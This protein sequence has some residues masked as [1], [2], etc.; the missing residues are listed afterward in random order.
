MA[1]KRGYSKA[2]SE[3]I[4]QNGGDG[5]T[6]PKS[7]DQR[8]RSVSEISQDSTASSL[9]TS[10]SPTDI[11]TPSPRSSPSPNSLKQNG[12]MGPRRDSSISGSSVG[13]L[14][15][16]PTIAK[17]SQLSMQ[18]S[19]NLD[20]ESARGTPVKS[21]DPPPAN[22]SEI[23]KK[24]LQAAKKNDS[25]SLTRLLTEFPN[26][27][28]TAVD[29]NGKTALH[30]CANNG[31]A[32][33][34]DTLLSRGAQPNM[35][36][37]NGNT[38]LHIAAKKDAVEVIEMLAVN[39]A[40][41]DFPDSK[42]GQTALH[43]AVSK[44]F[45]SSVQI[46][47]FSGADTTIK[48]KLGKAPHMFCKSKEM[49][50]LLAMNSS[51][52][53]NFSMGEMML[54]TVEIIGG[55]KTYCDRL[56]VHIDFAS[57][58]VGDKFSMMCRRQPIDFCDINFQFTASEEVISDVITYRVQRKGRKTLCMFTV[59]IYGQP[60]KTEEVVMKSN[61]GHN[62]VVSKVFEKDKVYYCDVSANL[63][64]LNAF[65]FV[66]RTKQESFTVSSDSTTITSEVNDNVK[67]ILPKGTFEEP[68]TLLL[69]VT[70]PPNPDILESAEMKDVYSLT[71]FVTVQT[72]NHVGPKQ[73][74]HIQLPLPEE[75]GVG[76]SIKVFTSN[77]YEID[78]ISEN[79]WTLLD[80]RCTVSKNVISFDA[81]SFS[82][83]VAVETKK[84]VSF[85]KLRPQVHS[86]FQRA[87]KR[88]HSVSF[89][90]MSRRLDESDSFQVAIE[91]APLDRVDTC[92]EFWVKE[93]FKD[94]RP[95]KSQSYIVK[96]KEQ[97]VLF[98]KN[99]KLLG[100]S[101]DIKFQFHPRRRNFQ[102]FTVE[103][104]QQVK[105]VSGQV[106]VMKILPN[107]D[108]DQNS[109]TKRKTKSITNILITLSKE[110]DKD[111]EEEEEEEK[112]IETVAPPIVEAPKLVKPPAAKP[113]TPSRNLLS[114][115]EGPSE[116]TSR[117]SIAVLK[118]KSFDFTL[119]EKGDPSFKGFTD[120]KF[121]QG[122]CKE[123]DEEWYK[124]AVL[125]GWN[126]ADI[127]RM[128]T[129]NNPSQQELIWHFLLSWRSM[130]KTKDDLGLPVLVT[131]LSKGGRKDLCTIIT[132]DL[133]D[134]A[135]VEDNQKSKFYRW[136]IKAFNNSDLMNPGDYPPPLSDQFLV[137][138]VDMTRCQIEILE[139]LGLTQKEIEKVMASK[140]YKSEDEKMLKMF[141]MAR[142]KA[143]LKKDFLKKLIKVLDQYGMRD[144]TRWL[145]IACR[146]WLEDSEQSGDPFCE[147]VQNVIK[148]I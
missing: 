19:F 64:E 18:S 44:N 98:V 138:L 60:L 116:P 128:V 28:L 86:L 29:E 58:A 89:L 83:K 90:A 135:K 102:C 147:D 52:A 123:M 92:K 136:V 23:K 41:L 65:V 72:E 68:T 3:A 80:T 11:P 30:Y 8:K 127:E 146:K 37:K 140:R 34:A 71:P 110:P 101:E 74:T 84:D 57:G 55:A 144:A 26:A 96:S 24:I 5:N 118:E 124:V 87:R 125:M 130:C 99:L 48:D 42:S 77:V 69:Q 17:G 10:P 73:E 75:Y 9:K 16:I 133:R 148:S 114:S 106:Q 121:L 22:N 59:P 38:P 129:E 45:L 134:W 145:I 14:S 1:M 132:L 112:E 111:E 108:E 95:K 56:D 78:D 67:L 20:L 13:G 113:I 122:I 109:E 61:Q 32:N 49:R 142:E 4:M 104:S 107:T 76:G 79:S 62:I 70:D 105:K 53:L 31:D 54:Q 103:T 36:D 50:S 131:A 94:Q 39:G 82:L 51:A 120:D 25:E 47:I 139:P 81:R 6:S 126:Y 43:Y 97:F 46:L 2:S 15:R 143:T 137:L 27:D 141:I 33:N 12:K 88:D 40:L 119:S 91:C 117:T 7:E 85:E 66:T 35:V 100:D 93:G 63:P 115:N 21:P